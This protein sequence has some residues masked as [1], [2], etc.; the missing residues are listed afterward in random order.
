MRQYFIDYMIVSGLI[1]G[2]TAFM[3]VIAA[4]IGERIF[5]GSKRKE[6]VN[7]SKHIQSG[8]N[9]VGG[10]NKTIS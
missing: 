6:H 8:W 2:I 3:G 10:K 9:L 1:I 4:S 5:G 7:E